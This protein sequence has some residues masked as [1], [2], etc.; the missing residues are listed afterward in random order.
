MENLKQIWIKDEIK[1]KLE[2]LPGKNM[3]ERI[4]GLIN[5]NSNKTNNVLDKETVEAIFCNFSTLGIKID[6]KD[7][8]DLKPI[9]DL[10]NEIKFKN[11]SNNA[12]ILGL[13]ADF[14][15]FKKEATGYNGY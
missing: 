8:I 7:T 13:K 2:L 10:L 12:L 3:S 15:K 11:E 14:E 6:E 9:I 4:D 1:A 5:I